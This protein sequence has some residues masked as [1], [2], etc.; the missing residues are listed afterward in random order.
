MA[1][2]IEARLRAGASLTPSPVMATTWPRPLAN[3]H[4]PSVLQARSGCQG[5][6]LIDAMDGRH[7]LALRVEWDLS[8]SRQTHFHFVAPQHRL[9]GGH[10][11]RALRRVAYHAP[12][13]LAV[14]LAA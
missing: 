1:M 7:A 13:G 5:A 10:H 14:V 9:G 8:D 11:Q 6:G 3:P 12:G 2:P 4:G